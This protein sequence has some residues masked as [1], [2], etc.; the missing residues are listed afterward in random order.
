MPFAFHCGSVPALHHTQIL[1][2]TFIENNIQEVCLCHQLEEMPVNLGRA[3]R[4][5]SNPLASLLAPGDQSDR[6]VRTTRGRGC[7]K[8]TRI[9]KPF[10]SVTKKEQPVRDG[11]FK[12][13]LRDKKAEITNMMDMNELYKNTI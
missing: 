7:S 8:K 12:Q 5:G 6:S 13:I 3:K 10:N 4:L 1:N 9:R 11:T 2:K